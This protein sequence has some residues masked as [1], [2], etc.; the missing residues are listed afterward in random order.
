MQGMNTGFDQCTKVDLLKTL[1]LNPPTQLHHCGNVHSDRQ[2]VALNYS[3]KRACTGA[4]C[5][6]LN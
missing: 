2:L 4:K 3:L 1:S 5:T 6:L